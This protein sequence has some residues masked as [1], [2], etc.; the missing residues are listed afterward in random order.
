MGRRALGVRVALLAA[1]A[2]DAGA[3]LGIEFLPW[4]NI[5]TAQEALR[6][7][8]DAGHA[9]GGIVVDVWHVERAAHR[10]PSSPSSHRTGS[11]AWS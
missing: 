4:S 5:P 9:A 11:S 3:R 7:V 6:L 1:Q 8:E 2:A 10:R